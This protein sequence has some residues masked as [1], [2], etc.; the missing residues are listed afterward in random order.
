MDLIKSLATPIDHRQ[1]TLQI[2]SFVNGPGRPGYDGGTM[3]D[4]RL[5]RRCFRQW[6]RGKTAQIGKFQIYEAYR[7]DLVARGGHGLW[8]RD[9]KVLE[10]LI[11]IGILS[12]IPGDGGSF[13]QWKLI[14]DCSRR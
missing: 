1:T 8:R 3:P 10:E 4:L 7:G 11:L 5:L 2:G 13:H 9:R 14:W 12:P 6:R